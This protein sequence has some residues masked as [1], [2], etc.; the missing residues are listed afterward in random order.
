M[1]IFLDA[2]DL[3]ERIATAQQNYE[4]L[5][6]KFDD[7]GFLQQIKKVLD[8]FAN[9]LHNIGLAV[10]AGFPY[11]EKMNV[12]STVSSLLE[13][14]RALR[15]KKLAGSIED[16]IVLR[17]IVYSIEDVGERIQR[18]GLYAGYSKSLTRKYKPP[19]DLDKFVHHSELDPRL[20]LE[21]LSLQSNYFRHAVRLTT[22]L[23]TGYI[24]SL[25]FPVGHGY[26]ILLT[27]TTIMKPAYSITRKRNVQRLLGTLAGGALSFALL[28]FVKNETA[29]FY[30]YDIN[31]DNWLQLYAHKLSCK[32]RGH[33]FICNYK[34]RFC[35]QWQFSCGTIRKNS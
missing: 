35:W 18:I 27:I 31:H 4:M 7:S 2:I 34:F 32:Q 24:I 20:L 15:E 28:F 25:F 14:Y 26:W 21:N 33:Y 17:Q 1:L 3:F 8:I 5:H 16:M 30:M 6:Q 19:V 10:Q 11:K 23:L 12:D 9:E 13:Q 29:L 22:A